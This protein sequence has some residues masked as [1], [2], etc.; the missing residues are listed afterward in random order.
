MEFW[1][2]NETDSEENFLRDNWGR[3]T[4]AANWFMATGSEGQH[5]SGKY[6]ARQNDWKQFHQWLFQF[7]RDV[8]MRQ[9][10]IRKADG[11]VADLQGLFYDFRYGWVGWHDLDEIYLGKTTCW[12]NSRITVGRQTYLSGESLLRGPDF[13]AIGAFCSI[14]ENFFAHAGVDRHPIRTASTFNF[15]AHGRDPSGRFT[16]DIDYP[17]LKEYPCGITIGNDVWF[18]RN[19]RIQPG[20]TIGDGCVIAEGSLVRGELQPYGLYAGTPARLKRF[21]FS[22]NIRLAL[23]ELAWWNWSSEKFQRNR[24]FFMADLATMDELPQD[25]IR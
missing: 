4:R 12:E 9:V 24:D 17:E 13:L 14:G 8:L 5:R 7:S 2:E 21:R 1:Q 23:Q 18:G 10:K 20:S 22:K 15:Q 25:L 16:L 19:V 6:L 11:A 3:S